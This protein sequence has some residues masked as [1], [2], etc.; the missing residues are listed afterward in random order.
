MMGEDGEEVN[1][2]TRPSDKVRGHVHYIFWMQ[3]L[4][5]CQLEEVKTLSSHEKVSWW[6]N[7]SCPACREV[8]RVG[9]EQP[10]SPISPEQMEAIQKLGIG[11]EVDLMTW[12]S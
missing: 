7:G 4:T 12:E 3:D 2:M 5:F 6:M 9:L 8:V 1:N 10:G 11:E